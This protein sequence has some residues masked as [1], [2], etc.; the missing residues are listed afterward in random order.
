MVSLFCGWGLTGAAEELDG[1]HAIRPAFVTW[2]S[3]RAN[4]TA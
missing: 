1:R 3:L 2:I 4:T